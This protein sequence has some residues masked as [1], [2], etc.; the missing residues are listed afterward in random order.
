MLDNRNKTLEALDFWEL[1]VNL[2]KI[3]DIKT[4]F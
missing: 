2:E 3:Q 4:F 1:V